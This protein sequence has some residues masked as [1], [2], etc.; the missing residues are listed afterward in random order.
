MQVICQIAFKALQYAKMGKK[1]IAKWVWR[2]KTFLLFSCQPNFQRMDFLEGQA[3]LAMLK[4]FIDALQ[5][6]GKCRCRERW[7][8]GVGRTVLCR[9]RA[10]LSWS[11]AGKTKEELHGRAD[12]GSRRKLPLWSCEERGKDQVDFSLHEMLH[13]SQLVL[14]AQCFLDVRIDPLTDV[15]FPQRAMPILLVHS[16]HSE[17]SEHGSKEAQEKKGK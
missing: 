14:F 16:S 12:S 3:G 15:H 2:G 6:A 1:A 8:D 11:L 17:R 13:N 5:V 4:Q 7:R 10:F 9:R